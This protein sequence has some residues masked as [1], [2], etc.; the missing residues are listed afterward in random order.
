MCVYYKL[1]HVN[2]ELSPQPNFSLIHTP[3]QY[4][5]KISSKFLFKLISRLFGSL[6]LSVDLL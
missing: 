2:L 5:I 3:I 6:M 1:L 4:K